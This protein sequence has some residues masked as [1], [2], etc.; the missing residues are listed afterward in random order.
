LGVL[1]ASSIT[2]LQA[3]MAEHYT[4]SLVMGVSMV[5]VL[6]LGAIVIG[7][8]PERHSINFGEGSTS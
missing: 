2:Y 4:Y 3:R 7:M 6:I 5:A 8:G 1:C